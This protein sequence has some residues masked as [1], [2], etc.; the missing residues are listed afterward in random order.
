MG[1]KNKF[2]NA[3]LKVHKTLGY[4]WLGGVALSYDDGSGKREFPADNYGIY[5]LSM[6][7]KPTKNMKLYCK[8][9]NIFNKYYAEHTDAGSDPYLTG[10]GERKYYAMPG[11]AFMV[12]LEFKF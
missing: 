10:D 6:N 3:V 2:V 9:E 5:N 8:V 1:F 12:G 7:Y 4:G 11:R